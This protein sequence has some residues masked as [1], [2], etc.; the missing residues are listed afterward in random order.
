MVTDTVHQEIRKAME[1]FWQ[2]NCPEFLRENNPPA[3]TTLGV[4]SLARPEF[5]LEILVVAAVE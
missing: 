2:I 1:E 5:L 4:T 3:A